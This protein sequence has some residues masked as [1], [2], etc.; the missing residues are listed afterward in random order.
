MKK[1]LSKYTV[2]EYN[3]KAMSGFDEPARNRLKAR[4]RNIVLT[5][6]AP[7]QNINASPITLQF[8]E[9]SSHEGFYVEAQHSEFKHVGHIAV[10]PF[11]DDYGTDL[12]S[13]NLNGQIVSIYT[14]DIARLDKRF[15]G[16]GLGKQM[17]K[18][19]IANLS[20]RKIALVPAEWH[21]DP[22]YEDIPIGERGT[23]HAALRVWRGLRIPSYYPEWKP[24]DFETFTSTRSRGWLTKSSSRSTQNLQAYKDQISQQ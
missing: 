2:D 1:A 3:N 4:I 22:D 19:L 13:Y 12:S 24:A 16:E 23:S 17:Y 10:I 14:V 5:E 21:P 18:F 6:T 9:E 8:R 20:Q 7:R 15:Q 11:W